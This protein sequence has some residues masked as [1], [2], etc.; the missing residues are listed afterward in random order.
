MPAHLNRH[1]CRSRSEL[2]NTSYVETSLVLPTSNP[3]SFPDISSAFYDDSSLRESFNGPRTSSS[4]TPESIPSLIPQVPP[5]SE[6]QDTHVGI[7]Y[8]SY[9][10]E[11]L[12]ATLPTVSQTEQ[13]RV[14]PSEGSQILAS[15]QLPPGELPDQLSY[16]YISANTPPSASGSSTPDLSAP[17]EPSMRQRKNRREKPH[18]RLAPDQPLT[19]SG[20][21]RARVYVACAQWYVC[22]VLSNLSG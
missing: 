4:S 16:N 21:P 22:F 18:L 3:L 2:P 5:R 19:T 10:E 15:S 7:P 13:A 1:S 14:N 6:F 9:P 8:P 20:T 17:S 11:F 12:H